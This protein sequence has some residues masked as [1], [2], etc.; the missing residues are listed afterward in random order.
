MM[1]CGIDGRAQMEKR[2]RNEAKWKIRTRQD[3]SLRNRV[4]QFTSGAAQGGARTCRWATDSVHCRLWWKDKFPQKRVFR[5]CGSSEK[6]SAATR[7]SR[8]CLFLFFFDISFTFVFH[9]LFFSVSW[10]M[11]SRFFFWL[12]FLFF[13]FHSSF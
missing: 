12:S 7:W 6:R 4:V 8:F 11:V 10:K 3:R 13:L 9:V 2:T 1:K 5:N